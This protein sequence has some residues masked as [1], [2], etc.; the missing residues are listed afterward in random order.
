MIPHGEQS[1]HKLGPA[2]PLLVNVHQITRTQLSTTFNDKDYKF[3][4]DPF[5]DRT[6]FQTTLPEKTKK[7]VFTIELNNRSIV[8]VPLDAT[9][10]NFCTTP[11]IVKPDMVKLI[12]VHETI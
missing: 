3:F 1:S 4:V 6:I 10:D 9:L 11:L 12:T 7:Y 8:Q 2:I 5:D